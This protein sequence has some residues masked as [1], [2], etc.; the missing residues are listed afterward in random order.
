MGFIIIGDCTNI[1]QISSLFVNVCRILANK[2]S[3]IVCVHLGITS[4]ARRAEFIPIPGT[5]GKHLPPLKTSFLKL[6]KFPFF[7]T[8]YTSYSSLC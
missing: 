1:A 3:Q 2:L 8:K 5:H 6:N 7:E 4:L